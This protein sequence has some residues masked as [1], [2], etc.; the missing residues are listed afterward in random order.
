MDPRQAQ[1]QRI[2]QPYGGL[3][4]Q[5]IRGADVTLRSVQRQSLAKNQG[6]L[7]GAGNKRR[8]TAINCDKPV[9]SRS[10]YHHFMR[11]FG[12]GSIAGWSLQTVGNMYP[13]WMLLFG[14]L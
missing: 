4:I 5:D 1:Q 10:S 14:Y 3:G 7:R 2:A 9:L 11:L 12:V 13:I 6:Q 8:L